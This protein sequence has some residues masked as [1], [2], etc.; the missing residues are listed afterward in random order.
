MEVFG[1]SVGVLSIATRKVRWEN[2][3]SF[4]ENEGIRPIRVGGRR[5]EK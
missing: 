2:L 5:S 3:W 1:A 4:L